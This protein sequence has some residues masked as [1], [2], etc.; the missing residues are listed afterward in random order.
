[1]HQMG[2]V[3]EIVDHAELENVAVQWAKE[4]N[5]KSLKPSAC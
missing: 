1:M 4:I 5:G 3:N 2:A